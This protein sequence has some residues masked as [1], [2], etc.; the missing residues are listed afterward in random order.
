MGFRGE[1]ECPIDQQ[2][3]T[4]LASQV[5]VLADALGEPLDG[6]ELIPNKEDR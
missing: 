6:T 1:Q 4:G 5:S 2:L 3:E